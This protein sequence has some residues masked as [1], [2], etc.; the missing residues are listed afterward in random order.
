MKKL[1]LASCLFF[2]SQCCA[3]SIDDLHGKV[4]RAFWNDFYEMK[5]LKF[6]PDTDRD[7]FIFLMGRQEAYQN[8]LLEIDSLKNDL[9]EQ[10]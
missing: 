9:P 1:I 3:D 10:E 2:S 6:K 5:N 7:R 8:V 4:F